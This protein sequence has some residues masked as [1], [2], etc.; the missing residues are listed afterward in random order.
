MVGGS[1]HLTGGSRISCH[2]VIHVTAPCHFAQVCSE[3]Y[4]KL[5][6]WSPVKMTLSVDFRN[7]TFIRISYCA[8]SLATKA[9]FY[10]FNSISL[11]SF[12]VGT[13]L[14]RWNLLCTDLCSWK[15]VLTQFWSLYLQLSA[16]SPTLASPFVK[17]P[18][19]RCTSFE[20]KQGLSPDHRVHHVGSLL[21]PPPC[22]YHP[23]DPPA[24]VK[25]HPCQAS[26]LAVFGVRLVLLWDDQ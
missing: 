20:G 23:S 8:H 6:N 22:R 24:F 10:K 15:K 11:S 21:S 1:V 14:N 4:S 13:T 25:L 7:T 18:R 9:A 19:G 5:L 26:Y 2:P 12:Q 17:R 16:L 3:Q